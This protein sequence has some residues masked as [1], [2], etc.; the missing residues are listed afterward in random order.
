[1]RLYELH[2]MLSPVDLKADF[3][4]SLQIFVVTAKSQ[5]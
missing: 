2:N 3:N 5:C 1:M 4:T